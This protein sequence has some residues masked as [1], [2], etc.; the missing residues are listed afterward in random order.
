MGWNNIHVKLHEYLST[1]S[2]FNEQAHNNII[3]LSFLM[4]KVNRI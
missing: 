1:G 2:E 4:N 3:I